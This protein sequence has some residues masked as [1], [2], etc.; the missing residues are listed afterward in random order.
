MT[1]EAE[2]WYKSK[3]IIM[4]MIVIFLLWLLLDRGSSSRS[5]ASR[6]CGGD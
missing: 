3:A 1:I 6:W 2:Q 5:N 4:G